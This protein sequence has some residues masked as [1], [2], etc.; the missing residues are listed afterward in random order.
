M[1]RA[2]NMRCSNLLLIVEM[3]IHIIK[4]Y[5][6]PDR[7]EKLC[8]TKETIH[9]MKRPLMEWEKVVINHI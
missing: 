9:K 4:S 2:K 5:I 6:P 3:Q 8:T 7:V 1:L